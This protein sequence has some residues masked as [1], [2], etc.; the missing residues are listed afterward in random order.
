MTTGAFSRNVGKFFSKLNLVT[1]N[2]S[3]DLYCLRVSG[4]KVFTDT[5]KSL[6]TPN[7]C[8]VDSSTKLNRRLNKHYSDE[9]VMMMHSVLS[10]KTDDK[11]GIK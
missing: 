4:N 7:Q 1:D 10:D 11:G 2:L 3:L 6:A 8:L 9:R 5:S